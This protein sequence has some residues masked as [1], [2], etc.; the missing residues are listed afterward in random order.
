MNPE[1]DDVDTNPRLPEPEENTTYFSV[2]VGVIQQKELELLFH[3]FCCLL[4]QKITGNMAEVLNSL[5]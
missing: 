2:G 4:V 3:K 5:L 1:E